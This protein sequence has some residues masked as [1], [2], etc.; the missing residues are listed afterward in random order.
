MIYNEI[1][2]KMLKEASSGNRS[3]PSERAALEF[4]KKIRGVPVKKANKK[5]GNFRLTRKPD[6]SVIQTNKSTK[7]LGLQMA[8]GEIVQFTRNVDFVNREDRDWITHKRQD[9]YGGSQGN[10]FME[11]LHMMQMW[12]DHIN[13][14]KQYNSDSY[15]GY[16]KMVFMAD[17]KLYKQKWFDLIKRNWNATHQYSEITDA[18]NYRKN[19]YP[20]IEKNIDI[21][22]QTVLEFC[23]ET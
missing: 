14:I 10:A 12:E 23:V 1:Y 5:N 21:E 8:K 4:L 3:N 20:N 13:Y 2:K 16:Y 9:E 17:G 19:E 7:E 11:G 22:D 6:G 18:E 15:K